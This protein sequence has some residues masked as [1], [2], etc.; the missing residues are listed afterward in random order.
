ML[1][2]SITYHSKY[3][4][5]V[6]TR[7]ICAMQAACIVYI[8]VYSVTFVLLSLYNIYTSIQCH[9]ISCHYIYKM[10]MQISI[11]TELYDIK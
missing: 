11:Q 1:F 2:Y 3:E 7:C 10:S 4:K 5:K 8:N 6:C 9:Y